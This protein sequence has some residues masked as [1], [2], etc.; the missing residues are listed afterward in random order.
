MKK[1]SLFAIIAS[2]MIFASCSKKITSNTKNSVSFPGMTVTRADYKLSKDVSAEVEVKSWTAL[3]G[4]LR[5]AK[6]V[7]ENKRELRQGIVNG[8]GL[9]LVS[10]IAL[11]RL[12]DANPNFDYLTNIR[13]TKEYTRKWLLFVTKY[14]TKVKIVAKGITLNTEK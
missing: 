3:M 11:Y 8:Y 5:G 10:Q 12:L 2:A 6:A 7:G 4:Y 9:D 13:V 14:N 1:F